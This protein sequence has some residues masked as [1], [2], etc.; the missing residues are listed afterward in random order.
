MY[1]NQH[2][3]WY[4]ELSQQFYYIIIDNNIPLDRIILMNKTLLIWC[5]FFFLCLFDYNVAL[6][7]IF[8][9]I[10]LEIKKNKRGL[11]YDVAPAGWRA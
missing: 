5:M 2:H 4:K 11:R 10:L 6:A 3:G 8:I 9:M 7:F 1:E